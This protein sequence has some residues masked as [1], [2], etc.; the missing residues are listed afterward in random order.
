MKIREKIE[1]IMMAATFAEAGAH[2]EARECLVDR[3]QL[4]LRKVKRARPRLRLRLHK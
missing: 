3:K 1:R 2:D 4:R